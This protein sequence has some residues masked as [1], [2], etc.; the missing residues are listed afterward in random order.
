MGE[1]E[2]QTERKANFIGF[3][4]GRGELSRRLGIGGILWPD[5]G[6]NSRIG[7][8]LFLGPGFGLESSQ[9]QGVLSLPP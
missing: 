7:G 5:F 8:I 9:G 2:Q 6:A 1:K 3:F 4:L